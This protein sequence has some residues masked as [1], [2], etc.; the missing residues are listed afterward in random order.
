MLVQH[1]MQWTVN[2]FWYQARQWTDRKQAATSYGHV[3]YAARKEGMWTGFATSAVASFLEVGM[4][5]E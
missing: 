2:Y 4:N 3:I 1:E 5:I